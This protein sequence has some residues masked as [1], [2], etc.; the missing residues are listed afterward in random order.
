MG[1]RSQDPKDVSVI[2][3]FFKQPGYCHTMGFIYLFQSPSVI[4]LIKIVVTVNAFLY[5]DCLN[6]TVSK[7]IAVAGLGGL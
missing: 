4:G 6:L 2:G 3:F 5:S 1:T 7:A